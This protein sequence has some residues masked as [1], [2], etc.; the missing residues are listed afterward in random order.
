MGKYGKER[1]TLCKE[2]AFYVRKDSILHKYKYIPQQIAGS[3]LRLK[4]EADSPAH[5]QLLATVSN[6]ALLHY[7][8]T[9]PAVSPILP[10][11]APHPALCLLQLS[12]HLGSHLHPCSQVEQSPGAGSQQLWL[13]KGIWTLVPHRYSPIALLRD[14]VEAAALKRCPCR[15]QPM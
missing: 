4:S 9:A 14:L 13:C 11:S 7:H 10:H 2:Q 12:L 8:Q 5:R 15:D 1:N 3:T 6:F